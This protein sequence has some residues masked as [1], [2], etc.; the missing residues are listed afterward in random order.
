M[1]LWVVTWR[2]RNKTSA[3]RVVDDGEYAVNDARRFEDETGV[4]WQVPVYAH[5]KMTAIF[6]AA[7]LI[8]KE[9]QRDATVSQKHN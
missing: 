6:D 7:G 4:Y 3:W 2:D 5:N 8:N 9:I 1:S